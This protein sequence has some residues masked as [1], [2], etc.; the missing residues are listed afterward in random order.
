MKYRGWNES[1]NDVVNRK[2]IL[3][4]VSLISYKKVLVTYICMRC[5]Y[6]S[7]CRAFVVLCI[8]CVVV[9]LFKDLVCSS[10]LDEVEGSVVAPLFWS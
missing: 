3:V 2:S 5:A 1:I 9:H 4:S 10:V 7:C 8:C 6:L